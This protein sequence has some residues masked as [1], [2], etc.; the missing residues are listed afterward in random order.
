MVTIAELMTSSG[1]GFGTSGARGLVSDMTD[2]V[3]YA[4][5]VG[6]LQYLENIHQLPGADPRIAIAGDLRPSTARIMRAVAQAVLDRGYQ[7]VN[8]GMIPSPAVAFYGRQQQIPTLMITGSHIPDDRNGIKFTTTAGEVLKAD[9]AGIRAQTV[10]IPARFASDGMLLVPGDLGSVDGAAHDAYFHRWLDAFPH[11]FLAGKRIGLYQHSAVGRDL[12]QDIYISLGAEVICLG[13]SDTFIPVD[14]EAIRQED[15]ELAAIW[16]RQYRC[17]ALLSTDG[18]SDRPLIADETGKWMRGD[19]AG[20]LCA[21]FCGA[22]VVVTP[23]SCST[24]VERCAWFRDV[25]RTRIG[26]PYV[27]EELTHAVRDGAQCAVGYEANGG[28]LTASPVHI[29]TRQ[30][31]PLPT[32]DAVLVHL[33]ILGLSIQN[34]KPISQLL[35]ELPQRATASDRLQHFPTAISQPHLDGLLDGGHTAISHFLPGLGEVVTVDTT[36]G[37]RIMFRCGEIV[38]LRP[39]GNAPE[40]RCYTEAATKVR[41]N[42]LLQQVMQQLETWRD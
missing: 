28:F 6:F 2:T 20:I 14:T 15:H 19:V 33:A 27:I 40:L 38:H 31:T 18:D 34:G 29:G 11:A 39:S 26:S 22:D 21:R 4:Y 5:T 24:A 1:V 10:A 25:R 30:L 23:V 8:C 32:R 3:C 42:A 36:D 13:R 37:L 12:L 35:A 17:D 41:A 9:E 7:P 16:A